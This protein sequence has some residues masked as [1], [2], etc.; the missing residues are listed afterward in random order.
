M[1]SRGGSPNSLS[2]TVVDVFTETRYTGNPLAIVLLPPSAE[3]APSQTQLQSIA[4]EFSLS[5]TIFLE[6]ATSEDVEKRTRRARIFTTTR[7]ILF[8]GHPTIGAAT[9]LLIHN[10]SPHG[11]QKLVPGAGPIA[12]S[13][14]YS[15]P[16]YVCAIIPH[17]YHHHKARCPAPKLLAL[18]STLTSIITPD[19]T[20]PIVSIVQ[21]MTWVL[22]ELQSLPALAAAELGNASAD[23]IANSGILDKDWEYAAPIGVY[24]YVRNAETEEDGVEVIR[25]RML[26]RGLEDP[27]TGSAAGALTGYAALKEAAKKGIKRTWKVVQGVEMGRRSEIGVKV[28]LKADMVDIIELSGTAVVV[29][30]GKIQL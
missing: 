5:E 25:T 16:G 28:E 7:E 12:I 23:I 19:Q 21:G 17:T 18:H 8:A 3:F 20:F 4:S 22:V 10:A 24:F 13:P 9:Y 15:K 30:N 29:S 1:P 27:A 14:V 6:Y 11:I 26:I 2:F